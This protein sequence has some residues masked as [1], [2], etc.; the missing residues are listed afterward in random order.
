MPW[1]VGI[2]SHVSVRMRNGKELQAWNDAEEPVTVFALGTNEL[3]GLD[4][5][6]QLSLLKMF[7][8]VSWH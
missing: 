4:A 6:G 8:R 5:D 1:I 2:T 3:K 7:P